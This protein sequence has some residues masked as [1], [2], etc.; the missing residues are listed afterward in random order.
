MASTA[1]ADE[2]GRPPAQYQE[3]DVNMFQFLPEIHQLVKAMTTATAP[4]DAAQSVCSGGNSC[5]C[6]LL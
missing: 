1:S 5:E 4:K 3:F 2:A 6:E